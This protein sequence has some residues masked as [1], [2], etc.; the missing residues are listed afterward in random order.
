MRISD[1]I[2]FLTNVATCYAMLCYAAVK[3]ALT[4]SPRAAIWSCDLCEDCCRDGYRVDGTAGDTTVSSPRSNAI[5]SHR[6]PSIRRANYSP[7]GEA[8]LVQHAR[9]HNIART[10][11]L[12]KNAVQQ[13]SLSM[14]LVP[15]AN[16]LQAA[17]LLADGQ[18][19]KLYLLL[20]LSSNVQPR[21]REENTDRPR[22]PFSMSAL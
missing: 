5:H 1:D 7:C 11:W 8:W 16:V 2:S 12:E 20:H 6:Q 17:P 10:A 4:A 21:L 14:L 9:I 19:I 15:F 18:D 3:R 13:F 22:T